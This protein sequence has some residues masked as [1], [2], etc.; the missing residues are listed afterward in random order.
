MK[1]LLFVLLFF[2]SVSWAGFSVCHDGSG[3]L[4]PSDDPSGICV[5][6]SDQTTGIVAHDRVRNV[7][8]TVPRQ[9]LKWTTE[10][11]EM[12]Q[13]EKDAV[14]AATII[15]RALAVKAAVDAEIDSTGSEGGA[16]RTI[17]L[18]MLDE[19]NILRGLHGL[20]ERTP[21]QAKDAFKAKNQSAEVD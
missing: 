14:D 17:M 10:P 8:K 15:T 9:Y 12:T 16:R 19:I 20:A 11:V 3:S 21:A 5:Y 6:Y 4:V 13:G 1:K 7:L 2:P 18:M